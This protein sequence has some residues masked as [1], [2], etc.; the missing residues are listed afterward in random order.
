[1]PAKTASMK[2]W[3][4]KLIDLSTSQ[5]IHGEKQYWLGVEEVN[6]ELPADFEIENFNLSLVSTV[7][8]S[9]DKDETSKLLKETN[10][11]YNTSV[12]ELLLTEPPKTINEWTNQSSMVIEMESHGRNVEGI[13]VSRTVGWFTAMYPLKLHIIKGNLGEQIMEIKEQI[14]S[15][16]GNGIGYGILKY[17]S[18]EKGILDYAT[19]IRRTLKR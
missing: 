5:K 14:R 12:E 4:E 9:L 6:F 2:E 7:K 19:F 16:P 17:L 10:K 15:V 11:A 13:D 3:Y 8:G 1:M 18:G